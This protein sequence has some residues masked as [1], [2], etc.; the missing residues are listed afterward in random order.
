MVYLYK[1]CRIE[2][3]SQL[4]NHPIQVKSR[5]VKAAGKQLTR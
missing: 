3:E 2:K 5:K 4:F 1:I